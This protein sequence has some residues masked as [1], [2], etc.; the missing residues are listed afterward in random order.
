LNRNQ[1]YIAAFCFL[2]FFNLIVVYPTLFYVQLGVPTE[3]TRYLDEWWERKEAYAASIP[4]KKLLVVSGSN[5]LFGVD[6]EQIEEKLQLPTVNFGTHAG[7]GLKYIL[8]RTKNSLQDGDIVLLPLEYTMYIHIEEYE[9]A[10][11]TY[12]ASRDDA[13]FRQK[14]IVEKI[15]FIA[16]MD[17]FSLLHGIKERIYPASHVIG[18][19]DS[20]YLNK[21][22][23]MLNNAVEKKLSREQ[24]HSKITCPTFGKGNYPSE[25]SRRCLLEFLDFCRKRQIKVIA[26]YPAYLYPAKTFTG[27]DLE[28]IQGIDDFWRQQGVPVLEKYTD[29]L[30][31]IDNFFDTTYH[32]NAAGKQIRTQQLIDWLKPVLAVENKN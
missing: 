32:L 8:E 27:Q 9:Q 20:T 15:R 24:L 6:T 31:D 14:S 18:R 19:Y 26:A 22:G 23:D 13:Y 1:K 11:T 30:Y 28:A 21:N 5:T 10:Y 17:L 29:S 12:I 25:E 4:G 7:L 16:S 3:G 2:V